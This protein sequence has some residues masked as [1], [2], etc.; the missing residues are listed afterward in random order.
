M[1]GPWCFVNDPSACK[2]G[3]QSQSRPGEVWDHC[4][5]GDDT[6]HGCH[7][8]LAWSYGGL[9]HSNCVHTKDHNRPWCYIMENDCKGALKTSKTGYY[10]DTCVETTVHG[11]HCKPLWAYHGKERY[12]CSFTNNH[13]GRW[14]HVQPGCAGA[15]KGASPWDDCRDEAVP[16]DAPELQIPGEETKHQCHCMQSWMYNGKVH[17]NCDSTPDHYGRWC[18]VMP[19]CSTAQKGKLPWDDCKEMAPMAAQVAPPMA[20][21]VLPPM[22]SA[23][24]RNGETTINM[25]HCKSQWEYHGAQMS[26]CGWTADSKKPWCFV[27]EGNAC[28]NGLRSS[29]YPEEVWDTCPVGT[30]TK[31]HCHC[32]LSWEYGGHAHS[33]CIHT[34][35]HHQPW[36]YVSDG[37]TCKG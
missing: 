7:C 23:V 30:E 34:K 26:N 16:A 24:L 15:Q 21:E 35:D 18:Y 28:K 14:C 36:C 6:S 37:E 1:D 19:G 5:E 27:S 9:S 22:A 29:T 2:N 11:C 13:H 3:H 8:K 4:P 12:G 33:N 32:L 25:C 17:S 20:S 31:H 10:W